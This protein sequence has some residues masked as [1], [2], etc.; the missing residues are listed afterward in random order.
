VTAA[1]PPLVAVELDLAHWP[2][3]HT[4]IQGCYRWGPAGW[5]VLRA[6][7]HD[8]LEWH[9]VTDRGEHV[10][11]G[12]VAHGGHGSA[13]GVSGG[14]LAIGHGSRIAMLTPRRGQTVDLARSAH[15]LSWLP[16]FSSGHVDVASLGSLV[17]TRHVTH[18]HA[19]VYTTR[20]WS[21]L[22][23]HHDHPLGRFTIP[24]HG[25]RRFQGMAL[26]ASRVGRLYGYG[27]SEHDHDPAAYT[28][29]WH[30]NHS[31]THRLTDERYWREGER[32]TS[33]EAE[34]LT[35]YL[36]HWYAGVRLSRGAARVWRLVRLP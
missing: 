14:Q 27:T 19:E 10:S 17:L 30:G 12:R 36:G 23:R 6:A 13:V 16:S 31:H 26:G 29:D 18:D 2:G 33:R 35:W 28:M 8:I 20:R 4:E 32:W 21:D 5:M 25:G 7:T 22:A 9:H 3:A 24:H 1:P 34:G 15:E 11:S